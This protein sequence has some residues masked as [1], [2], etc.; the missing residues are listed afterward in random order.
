[1]DGRW[2]RVAL[3]VL[4]HLNESSTIYL[5]TRFSDFELGDESQLFSIGAYWKLAGNVCWQSA[6]AVESPANI[7]DEFH[8]VCNSHVLI[9]PV[10]L[11]RLYQ[12]QL[13]TPLSA[14]WH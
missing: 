14:G 8:H 13:I 5:Y 3:W 9:L 1:Y 10:K 11:A 6:D 7:I 12:W 4:V 2:P